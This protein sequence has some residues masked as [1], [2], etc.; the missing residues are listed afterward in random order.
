MALA[1]GSL[2]DRLK[3]STRALH[4]RLDSHPAMAGLME[5][6]LSP[7][8]YAALLRS[9]GVAYAQLEPE[10]ENAV[11]RVGAALDY[12]ERRKLPALERDL[13]ALGAS[14]RLDAHGPLPWRIESVGAL[15]GTLYT[16]EGSTLGGQVI[17]RSL[18]KHLSLGPSNGGAF[19]G[20]YGEKTRERWLSFLGFLEQ[21]GHSAAERDA[22]EAYAQR[23]FELFAAALDAI[24]C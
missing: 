19:F 18:A 2:R 13:S 14:S 16:V 10:I 5:P 3:M 9:F 23:T 1:S 6:G 11:A 4:Q 12:T 7:A 21:A 24:D 22:A 17:A 20:G 8:R 15:A